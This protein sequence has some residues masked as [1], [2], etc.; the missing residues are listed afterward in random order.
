[1][2]IL[3]VPMENESKVHDHEDKVH[4]QG[5]ELVTT[6]ANHDDCISQL[7]QS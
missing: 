4:G 3:V 1:M 2:F 5:S 7:V 6:V